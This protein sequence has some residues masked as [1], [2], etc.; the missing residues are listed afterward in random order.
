[1]TRSGPGNER[2]AS[3][4]VVTLSAVAEPEVGDSP[5]RGRVRS[6]P[7]EGYVQGLRGIAIA[8]VVAF[9]LQV[10]AVGGGL[11]GVDV[12]FVISGFVITRSLMSEWLRTSRIGLVDFFARRVRRLGPSLTVVLLGIFAGMVLLWH[13]SLR[14]VFRGEAQAAT[15]GL[16]NIWSA[17]HAVIYGAPNPLR[18]PFAHLW[19]LAVEEQFYLVVAPAM[20][21][22]LATPWGRRR[23]RRTLLAVVGATML[24]SYAIG[25]RYARSANP[26][27]SFY[28]LDA[29]A[30]EL[31]AG[32]ALAL[33]P[34]LLAGTR[35]WREPAGWIGL[36][37]LAAAVHHY[38][39]TGGRPTQGPLLAVIAAVLI[40]SSGP[41]G[42]RW[43]AGRLLSVAPLRAVGAIAYPLYLWHW[44][45]LS[46]LFDRDPGFAHARLIVVVGSLA[47]AWAT[48]VLIEQRVRWLPAL[49]AHPRVTV[50]GG[51]AVA[52]GLFTVATL[53]TVPHRYG[54]RP[55]GPEATSHYLPTNLHPP[56]LAGL[57]AAGS[58]IPACSA[59]G[60]PDQA[61]CVL[62]SPDGDKTI[63]AI[64]DSHMGVV[65]WA[66]DAAGKQAGWRVIYHIEG[67]CSWVALEGSDAN[68]PR[69]DCPAA[70]AQE[71]ELARAW[72][73]DL[74]IA[75][76]R[77]EVQLDHTS[78]DQ[79]ATEM[80]ATMRSFPSGTPVAVLG[81]VPRLRDHW[82]DC[83]ILHQDD[84]RS[85]SID[86]SS[87]LDQRTRAMVRSAAERSGAHY[88]D[89]A[90]FTCPERRCPLVRGN[91][92]V[93]WDDDH[94]STPYAV[95]L[96]PQIRKVLAP[97]IAAGAPAGS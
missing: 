21:L 12:F 72:K 96:A 86:R 23:P 54:V 56:L 95:T 49:V 92:L 81:D 35:W 97:L 87:A 89:L 48:H 75:A 7:M 93:Y 17:R 25:E 40:I 80:A 36:A 3:R 22:V 9:H 45:L 34:R 27:N 32:G 18:S 60:G 66:L 79:Y 37:A 30:W 42:H 39:D 59:Q 2:R 11:Y 83:L 41:G 90:G 68:I 94:L 5:E 43:S 33:L 1:M 10:A 52:L 28:R 58:P 69:H 29:R 67:G 88:I 8:L 16:T 62:G 15:V 13:P 31:L 47:L 4:S 44:V 84:T 73:P 19:S 46:F 82:Q 64:G 26:A 38:P 55:A 53:I 74:I 76:N 50:L 57:A 85:C 71:A 63:L 70:R 6:A 61:T 24:A 14:A 78:A 77:Y 65:L 20:A 51:I 91:V